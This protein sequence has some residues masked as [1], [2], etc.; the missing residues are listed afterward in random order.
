MNEHT[1]T[2]VTDYALGEP[3]AD[4]CNWKPLKDDAELRG[5]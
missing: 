3:E 5:G 2:R 1:D 4:R